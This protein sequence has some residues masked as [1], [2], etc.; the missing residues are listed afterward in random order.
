LKFGNKRKRIRLLGKRPKK[1]TSLMTSE[2]FGAYLDQLL[3]RSKRLKK[4]G[5]THVK[6]GEL[7]VKI[8][9]DIVIRSTSPEP[10]PFDQLA[11]PATGPYS[12]PSYYN[13]FAA[14][15]YPRRD[16]EE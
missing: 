3:R 5:V 1:R 2:E 8:D 13:G 14:P 11:R 12:D 6:F 15:S 7:E 4:M 9:Q 10:H 16:P